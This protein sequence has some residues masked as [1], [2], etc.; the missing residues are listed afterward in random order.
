M[1]NDATISPMIHDGHKELK[2]DWIATPFQDDQTVT[3]L[4]LFFIDVPSSQS[5]SLIHATNQREKKIS[6]QRVTK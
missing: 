3:R 6:W 4:L 1:K 2:E 5:N